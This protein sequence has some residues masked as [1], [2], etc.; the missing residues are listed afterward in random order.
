MQCLAIFSECLFICTLSRSTRQ[1]ASISHRLLSHTSGHGT[2]IPCE[3]YPFALQARPTVL[4]H[5]SISKPTPT[6]H[7]RAHIDLLYICRSSFGDFIA[8]SGVVDVATA[9]L[10]KREV[11]DGIIAR[12]FEPEALEILKAKK[13]GKYLVLQVSVCVCAYQRFQRTGEYRTRRL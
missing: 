6:G 7:A 1:P 11:S 2:Q 9:K 8:I 13:G 10:I 4:L 5:L 12:G 3:L